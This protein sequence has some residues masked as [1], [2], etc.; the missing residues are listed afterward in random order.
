MLE[1]IIKLKNRNRDIAKKINHLK[2][3]ITLL[4]YKFSDVKLSFPHPV[5]S[6]KEFNDYLTLI[7]S[8]DILSKEM[9]LN[10]KNLIK[11]RNINV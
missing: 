5:M 2:M 7:N 4:N 3:K 8:V 1:N 6:E 10:S 9:S 11:W